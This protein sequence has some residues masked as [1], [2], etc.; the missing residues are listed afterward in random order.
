MDGC[1]RSVV[2]KWK[3]KFF[4]DYQLFSFLSSVSVLF[5]LDHHQNLH[6]SLPGAHTA[7]S[8]THHDRQNPDVQNPLIS[9][10]HK[11]MKRSMFERIATQTSE[12]MSCPSWN[13]KELIYHPHVCG[14]D[15]PSSLT[16]L[17]V[18][19]VYQPADRYDWL[20]RVVRHLVS[21]AICLCV[22][23]F[24]V[25]VFGLGSIVLS[26]IEEDCQVFE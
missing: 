10:G 17:H 24:D 3:M 11:C 19:Q 20:P 18:S 12:N 9:V 7:R 13:V 8:V 5:R 2:S 1:N 16:C 23:L 21:P 4:F 14:G 22:P 15:Q 6:V 25:A 26:P